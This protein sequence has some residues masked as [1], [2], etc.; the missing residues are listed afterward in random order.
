MQEAT[1]LFAPSGIGPAERGRLDATLEK[2]GDLYVALRAGRGDIEPAALLAQWRDDLALHFALEEG[3]TYFGSFL[4]DSPSLSHGIAELRAEHSSLLAEVERVRPFA[5]DRAR[6]P[7]LADKTLHL[8]E[9]FRAHEH[10]ETDLLQESVLRD[11]GV[12]AD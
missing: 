7:E 12:G 1:T 3:D 5:T 6:W 11:D 4:R 8:I 9:L 10:K 2:L